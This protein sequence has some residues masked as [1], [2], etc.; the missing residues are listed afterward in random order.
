MNNNKRILLVDDEPDI[1]YSFRIGL[2]NNG[3]K[4]DTFNNPLEASSNFKSDFYDLVVLDIKMPEM[5]GI[6]LCKEIR[7]MDS[8]IKICFATAFD[9]RYG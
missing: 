5:N 1:T 7:K 8:E 3:F 9:S 4:V 6:D 2:E